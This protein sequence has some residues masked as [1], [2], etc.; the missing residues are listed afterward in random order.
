MS[1]AGGMIS[2]EASSFG[3]VSSFPMAPE[4]PNR[5]TAHAIRATMDDAYDAKLW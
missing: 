4:I 2:S 1:D 5:T 3:S